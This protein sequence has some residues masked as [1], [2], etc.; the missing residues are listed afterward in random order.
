M[1]VERPVRG[2]LSKKCTKLGPKLV[3]CCK[4]KYWCPVGKAHKT[5]TYLASSFP[6]NVSSNV[7][8]A[9]CSGELFGLVATVIV[10]TIMLHLTVTGKTNICSK[11]LAHR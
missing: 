8:V 5:Q 11:H 3:G 2:S 1:G 6:Q 9:S 10:I 7:D 4:S